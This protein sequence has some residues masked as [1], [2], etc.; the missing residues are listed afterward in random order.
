[1]LTKAHQVSVVAMQLLQAHYGLD[2]QTKTRLVPMYCDGR[3]VEM[4]AAYALAVLAA[5][6][7]D[8]SIHSLLRTERWPMCSTLLI[9]CSVCAA[10]EVKSMYSHVQLT[11]YFDLA[12]ASNVM[13]NDS[14]HDSI[15]EATC[16]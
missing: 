1:M 4:V 3:A 2:C 14:Y 6:A 13:I 5:A 10:F 9:N 7:P 15:L 8:L 16:V 11:L 12:N